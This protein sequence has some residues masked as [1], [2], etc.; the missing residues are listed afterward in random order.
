MAATGGTQFSA[1]VHTGAPP[2]GTTRRTGQT[3]LRAHGAHGVRFQCVIKSHPHQN[4]KSQK[5]LSPRKQILWAAKGTKLCGLCVLCGKITIFR[6]RIQRLRHGARRGVE[7]V[8]P[9]QVAT[10]PRDC[11]EVKSRGIMREGHA[12]RGRARAGPVRTPCAESPPP[13]CMRFQCVIK[14]YPWTELSSARTSSP[15]QSNLVGRKG[16]KTLRSCVLCGKN[17]MFRCRID[18]LRKWPWRGVEAWKGRDRN[19]P[20]LFRS[21]ITRR[22]VRTSRANFDKRSSR[23]L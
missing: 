21:E 4:R 14:S 18:R 16:H 17:A 9:Q 22:P 7:G 1:S 3:L 8:R 11:S 23:L 6:C 19:C 15:R 5:T 2:T 13:L 12:C 20:E 10:L